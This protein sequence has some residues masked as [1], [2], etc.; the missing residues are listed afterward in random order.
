MKNEKELRQH[1]M[2]IREERLFDYLKGVMRKVAIKYANKD[3]PDPI[4][5]SVT[6]D[7]NKNI[8]IVVTIPSLKKV[9]KTYHSIEDLI[10]DDSTFDDVKKVVI[11]TIAA[12]NYQLNKADR[13]LKQEAIC[14]Q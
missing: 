9:I 13:K 3:E 6:Q 10:S 12:V 7:T 4:A 14:H 5:F 11:K 8:V 1:A 2:E